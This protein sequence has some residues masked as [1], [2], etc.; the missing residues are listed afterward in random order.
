[1][2]KMNEL[3]PL[4]KGLFEDPIRLI[5]FPFDPQEELYRV[6]ERLIYFSF[7]ARFQEGNFRT[8]PEDEAKR[9]DSWHES[10]M[11]EIDGEE[12]TFRQR[13][14][15]ARRSGSINPGDYMRALIDVRSLLSPFEMARS[16]ARRTYQAH[17][18]FI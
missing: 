7:S 4:G 11:Q 17:K 8:T 18:R 10:R 13:L 14:D 5:R 15:D 1:M 12:R 3:E 2:I 6:K 9:V 16:E